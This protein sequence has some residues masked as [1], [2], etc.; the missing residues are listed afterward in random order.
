MRNRERQFNDIVD[1]AAEVRAALRGVAAGAPASAGAVG[2]VGATGAAAATAAAAVGAAAS[3]AAAPA[4]VNIDS[5]GSMDE[6][7]LQMQDA[8]RDYDQ[9]RHPR[10]PGARVLRRPRRFE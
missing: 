9:D 7:L 10:P 3:A 6:A 1:R 8:E 4:H 2:A 5:V